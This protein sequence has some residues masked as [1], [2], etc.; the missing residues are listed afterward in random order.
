LAPF[1]T[2]I[3]NG[4]NKIY[5]AI[6]NWFELQINKL[7]E[8]GG[9]FWQQLENLQASR[10]VDML[11]YDPHGRNSQHNP[12]LINQTNSKSLEILKAQ[13]D[14]IE[15]NCGGVVYSTH[16]FKFTSQHNVEQFIEDKRVESCGTD[17]DL[18]SILV[19]MGGKKQ[20]GHQLGQITFAASWVQMTTTLDFDLLSSKSFERPLALFVGGKKQSGHQLGQITFAT[21]WVQMTT[22]LDFDLLSS[23]SFERP[24]ALF[25]AGASE[26]DTL[27]CPLY[28][29]WVSVGLKT[30]V[31]GEYHKQCFKVCVRNSGHLAVSVRGHLWAMTL[32]DNVEIQYN[33]LVA[34]CQEVLQ[35]ID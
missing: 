5:E 22:T 7:K 33:K 23:K 20:S 34:F 14:N 30:S 24:L 8:N 15:S 18:F 1:P 27:K 21:S 25:V 9:Q 11:E 6:Q 16:K 26:M 28:K 31:S 35:G 4:L 13:I 10:D 12:I 32:L 2:R 19:R 3:R 17:W 29:S